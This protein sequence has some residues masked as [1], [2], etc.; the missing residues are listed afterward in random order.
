MYKTLNRIS[1]QKVYIFSIETPFHMKS[2]PHNEGA[3]MKTQPH[4]EGAR[5]KTHSQKNKQVP[6]QQPEAHNHGSP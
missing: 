5:M 3:H 1:Q 2:P 6:A 4:N